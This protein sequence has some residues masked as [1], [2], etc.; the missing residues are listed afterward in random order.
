ML[1]D[2]D[3]LP[4]LRPPDEDDPEL[5]DEPDEPEL[6]EPEELDPPDLPPPPLRFSSRFSGSDETSSAGCD[7][8]DN[9]VSST[10][11]AAA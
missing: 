7:H 9:D 10:G 8:K 6:E 11:M 4:E 2:D 3:V 1:D 5:P